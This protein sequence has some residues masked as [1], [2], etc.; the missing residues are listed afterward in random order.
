MVRRRG[1]PR[2]LALALL[3]A[4]TAIT[5]LEGQGPPTEPPSP[6]TLE[7]EDDIATV[8]GVS[9]GAPVGWYAL[10]R[11]PT[12]YTTRTV[13]RAGV[14]EADA[15]GVLRVELEE[16]VSPISAWLVVD[17]ATGAF[18]VEDGEWG[19]SSRSASQVSRCAATRGGS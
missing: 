14:A 11:Y 17:L 2:V 9:P 8:S 10:S 3:A 15:T 13:Q 7:L 6:P 18:T 5:R 19:H 16:P 1:C 4:L 12:G